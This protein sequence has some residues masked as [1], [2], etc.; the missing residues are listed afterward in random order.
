MK[1]VLVEGDLIIC[2]NCKCE[3][4]RVTRDIFKNDIISA[5]DFNCTKQKITNFHQKNKIYLM[6]PSL[7]I[8]IL[9]F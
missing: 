7:Y 5:E 9:L 3:V 2:P 4:A 6:S 8:L 1:R